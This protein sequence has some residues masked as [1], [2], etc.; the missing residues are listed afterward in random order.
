M[1]GV[2]P[3]R[4]WDAP[5]MRSADPEV[6]YLGPMPQAPSDYYAA[7]ILFQPTARRHAFVYLLLACDGSVIYVGKARRPGNRFD[8]HRRREW[9]DEVESLILLRV[10][11]EVVEDADVLALHVESLLIRRFDPPYNV[12]GARRRPGCYR[13]EFA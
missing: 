8:K 7:S 4:L 9:W 11:A 5:A 13:G 10:G 2:I 1:I 6:V 12:A 3:N